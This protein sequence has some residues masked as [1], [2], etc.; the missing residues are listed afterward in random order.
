MPTVAQ[1]TTKQQLEMTL[2]RFLH[3]HQGNAEVE[4]VAF[5]F[6]RKMNALKPRIKAPEGRQFLV[7]LIYDH[8]FGVYKANV[9]E[10]T[11]LH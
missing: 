11:Y 5:Q 9:T 6:N 3:K 2:N 7:K 8:T 4:A 10:H 1:L